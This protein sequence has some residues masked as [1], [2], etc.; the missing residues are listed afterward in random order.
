MSDQDNLDPVFSRTT[1][2]AIEDTIRALYAE[3][4]KF[5]TNSVYISHPDAAPRLRRGLIVTSIPVANVYLVIPENGG[6]IKT[7]VYL[8]RGASG[9]IGVYDA[10]TLPPQTTVWYIDPPQSR[11]G[12]IIGVEPLATLIPQSALNEIISHEAKVG[13]LHQKM[14]LYPLNSFGRGQFPDFSG[15][16]PIDSCTLGE[17]C[18]TSETGTMLFLDQLMGFLRANEFTGFWCFI[19]ESL[20]RMS[21][22]NLEIWSGLSEFRTTVSSKFNYSYLGI[23]KNIFHQMG[24]IKET[25][26]GDKEPNRKQRPIHVDRELRGDTFSGHRL[27]T[28]AVNKKVSNTFEYGSSTFLTPLSDIFRSYSGKIGIKS[29]TG[30]HLIKSPDIRYVQEK[31]PP[32][33]EKKATSSSSPA[34]NKKA[35]YQ[36]EKLETHK[37]LSYSITDL[38]AH[39]FNWE[40]NF[41]VV[42]DSSTNQFST[43]PKEAVAGASYSGFSSN[44]SDLDPPP[45]TTIHLD[46]SVSIKRYNNH[47]YIS[48]TADG[49]ILLGDGY[50]GQI[51]M[52]RGRIYI[53]APLGIEIFSGR[54]V[55]VMA[56]RD[57]INRARGSVDLS[58]TNGDIR[59]ISGGNIHMR[60]SVSVPNTGIVMECPTAGD[61]TSANHEPGLGAMYPG[62]YLISRQAPVCIQG[63]SIYED[64]HEKILLS[65]PS[66]DVTRLA[67]NAIDAI[68]CAGYQIFGP[69]DDLVSYINRTN[70]DAIEPGDKL[71]FNVYTMAAVHFGAD[72]HVQYNLVTSENVVSA[73]HVYIGGVQIANSRF[74]EKCASAFEFDVNA[75]R[76]VV[77]NYGNSLV[78]LANGLDY[79]LSNVSV[80]YRTDV[81]YMTVGYEYVM[82]RWCENAPDTWG[83][84][85]VVV[86][87]FGNRRSSAAQNPDNHLVTYPFPGAQFYTELKPLKKADLKFT[88]VSGDI[89]VD[90]KQMN[91]DY[92]PNVSDFNM[93]ELK[94]VG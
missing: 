65:A 59:A 68:S 20:A 57:I 5:E 21:G 93:S 27:L 94:V 67:K 61:L 29:A 86:P 9:L 7:C 12:L 75:L 51:S 6:P 15:K 90:I 85:P 35:A 45:S 88:N 78:T 74:A 52:A 16:T 80:T 4:N 22:K 14:L 43:S 31:Y 73:K 91:D 38:H 54:T 58:C 47:S 44:Y 48:M 70:D 82:P 23:A 89:N 60:S 36:L 25:Q 69:T 18:F 19:Q 72:V 41:K 84:N 83:E 33:F 77:Q 24:H 92:A 46:D 8:M 64:A 1:A 50:G 37:I 11:F 79:S 66:G 55:N 42:E 63:K 39:L 81:D 56:G 13:P 3:K 62:I 71:Y 2:T 32:G 49:S 10:S 17:L 53:T 30:I 26:L 40:P 34:S 28:L 76:P 87:P